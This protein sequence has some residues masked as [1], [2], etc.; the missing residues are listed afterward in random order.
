MPARDFDLDAHPGLWRALAD[1]IERTYAGALPPVP[2]DAECYLVR[3]EGETAGVLVLRR[4]APGAGQAALLA[5]AVDPAARGRA[6]G[7][8]ALLAAERRLRRDGLELRARVPRTNGRGLY[9]MLR[10]GFTPVA[11]TEGDD[12][13]WF[14][15]RARIQG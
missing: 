7:T 14:R 13:T 2:P 12:A 5:V 8:K 4:D 15:R 9:F 10:A 6:S 1:G 3:V 11:P